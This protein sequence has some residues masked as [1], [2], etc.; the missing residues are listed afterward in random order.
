MKI[1]RPRWECTLIYGNGIRVSH[2][3]RNKKHARELFETNPCVAE[4]EVY[5]NYKLRKHYV[6]MIHKQ[7]R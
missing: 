4:A 2:N 1:K 6:K 5:K 7:E 3:V